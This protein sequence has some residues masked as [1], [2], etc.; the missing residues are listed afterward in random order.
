MAKSARQA[1][2]GVFHR[3]PRLCESRYGER[4][5]HRSYAVRKG[6]AI[7]ASQ[8]QAIDYSNWTER[9]TFLMA[10]GDKEMLPFTSLFDG[11]LLLALIEQLSPALNENRAEQK[12]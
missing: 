3:N 4:Y 9:I 8:I 7:E 10:S 5:T 1:S 11:D 6:H 12:A 2:E